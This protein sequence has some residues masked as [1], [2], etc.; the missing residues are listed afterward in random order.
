MKV[1]SRCAQRFGSV[2][3]ASSAARLAGL[4]HGKYNPDFQ[5][6]INGARLK[7]DHFT[8]AAATVL[9]MAGGE[10]RI[11]ADLLAYRGV[12]RNI[13]DAEG[14]VNIPSRPSRRGVDRNSTGKIRI[15]CGAC[16]PAGVSTA[17]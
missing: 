7:V 2:F 15:R 9:Q 12:D 8:A 10:D 5:A 13:H 1:V 6:Y 14:R 4:L 17:K 3:G 16:A 11:I